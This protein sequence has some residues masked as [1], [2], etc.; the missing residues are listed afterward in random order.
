MW[1]GQTVDKKGSFIYTYTDWKSTHLVKLKITEWT[2]VRDTSKKVVRDFWKMIS[3]KKEALA[4]FSDYAII[5]NK[6]ILKNNFL[7]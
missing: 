5:E 2:N 6:I 1:D 3:T 7:F 4:I